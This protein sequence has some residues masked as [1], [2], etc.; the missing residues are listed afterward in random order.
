ML[1]FIK[2]TLGGWLTKDIL[3][4]KLHVPSWSV[5]SVAVTVKKHYTSF[6]YHLMFISDCRNLYDGIINIPLH[7]SNAEVNCP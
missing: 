4:N 7:T 6:M 1:T 5:M 2:I 3:L